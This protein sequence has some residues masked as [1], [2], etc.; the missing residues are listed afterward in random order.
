MPNNA[1]SEDPLGQLVAS[2]QRMTGGLIQITA[3]D[4]LARYGMTEQD[5]LAL[6][7]E[8]ARY[9]DNL[10]D[11]VTTDSKLLRLQAEG[12]VGNISRRV[13]AVLKRDGKTVRTLYYREE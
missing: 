3:Q 8:F 7:T 9:A 2:A 13:F 4:V 5:Y 6:Q 1:L 10:K 11:S 12:K